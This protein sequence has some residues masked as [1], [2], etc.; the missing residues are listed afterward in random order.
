MKT[1][2]LL[3]IFFCL[4]ILISIYFYYN[5]KPQQNSS[6]VH[7]SISNLTLDP[8][9][10]DSVDNKEENYSWPKSKYYN[11]I[12]ESKGDMVEP[13]IYYDKEVF[14]GKNYE[15][16]TGWVKADTIKIVDGKLYFNLF[17]HMGDGIKFN[18]NNLQPIPINLVK[19]WDREEEISLKD[20]SLFDKQEI[21]NIKIYYEQNIDIGAIS[22]F[23][24]KQEALAKVGASDLEGSNNDSDFVR[25]NENEPTYI[26]SNSPIFKQKIHKVILRKPYFEERVITY[27]NESTFNKISYYYILERSNSYN[28]LV[29]F[30]NS[31]WIKFE[32]NTETENDNG[33]D[34]LADS[35]G[36][37][38]KNLLHLDFY[39]SEFN[40][41]CM[42]ITKRHTI[43]F[44]FNMPQNNKDIVFYTKYQDKEPGDYSWESDTTIA[45][46]DHN[47]NEFYIDISKF[48]STNPKLKRQNN[49]EYTSQGM[50]SFEGEINCGPL[51]NFKSV[52]Q[53]ALKIISLSFK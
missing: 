37:H 25:E 11:L 31:E 41:S 24:Y 53:C 19:S 1:K 46:Y 20:L 36:D 34:Y 42:V 43:E 6:L 49:E 35:F 8:I 38:S 30:N 17:Q 15:T 2:S 13:D 3:I 33:Y 28:S 23:L 14:D 51:K 40:N 48:S 29:K 27:G 47:F 39:C 4:V 21:I 44:D 10:I 18:G 9:A 26:N 32:E 50:L 16:I 12:T 7:N 45:V 22:K 5:R 52:D